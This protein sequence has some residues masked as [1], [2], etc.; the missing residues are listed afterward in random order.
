MAKKTKNTIVWEWTM[1]E[2]SWYFSDSFIKRFI[3]RLWR[4]SFGALLLICL[5]IIAYGILWFLNNYIF[6]GYFPFVLL[7]IFIVHIGYNAWKS[8]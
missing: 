3:S 7:L 8:K 5:G 6:R 1:K 4:A 2:D